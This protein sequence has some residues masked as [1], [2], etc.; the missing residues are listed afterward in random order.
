MQGFSENLYFLYYP[1]LILY[2]G[3]YVH[4]KDRTRICSIRLD[5]CLGIPLHS[6]HFMGPLWSPKKPPPRN[7]L[8]ELVYSEIPWSLLYSWLCNLAF[9]VSGCE[10]LHC[11]RH[12]ARALLYL[13][14]EN[15][16]TVQSR[17]PHTREET[18]IKEVLSF[19]SAPWLIG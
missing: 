16:L 13:S 10:D 6:A 14:E 5:V 15:G 18:I 2:C 3:I 8:C 9:I 1:D 11:V 19:L 17:S 4:L 12:W 7:I